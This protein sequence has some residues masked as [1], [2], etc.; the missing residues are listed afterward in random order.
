MLDVGTENT[1]PNISPTR[2]THFVTTVLFFTLD[3][4]AYTL[5][6]VDVKLGSVFCSECDDFVYDRTFDKIF[7][8][9]VLD[10][11]EKTTKFQGD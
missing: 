2:A 10:V 9:T 7:H 8:A 5:V 4:R 11:E 3:R 6:G 1:P